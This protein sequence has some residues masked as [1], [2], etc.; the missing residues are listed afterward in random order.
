MAFGLGQR[1]GF[2]A[3]I[4]VTPL[5]DVVLV[6]LIIFMVVTPLLS[7]GRDIDLPKAHSAVTRS[8]VADAGLVLSVTPDGDT[9]LDARKVSDG[10][11]MELATQRKARERYLHV[12][13]RAD[14]RVSVKAL[15]PLLRTLKRAGVTQIS[16]AVLDADGAR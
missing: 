4:N 7:R 9:W 11:L 6:L 15:R 14:S 2:K 5:V 13:I 3:E 8:D 12:L 10:E 16:F 1:A